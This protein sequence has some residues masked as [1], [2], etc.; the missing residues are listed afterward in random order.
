MLQ[1]VFKF[2]AVCCLLG[3]GRLVSFLLLQVKVVGLEHAPA[4]G[5]LLVIANHFSWFDAPL[6]TLYLPF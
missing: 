6:L 4:T 3:I 1:K 2:C 5:S